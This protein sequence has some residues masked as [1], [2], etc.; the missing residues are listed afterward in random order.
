MTFDESAPRDAGG[1]LIWR[2]PAGAGV[3]PLDPNTA[4]LLSA[5]T[6]QPHALDD[7]RAG[8]PARLVDR[9]ESPGLRFPTLEAGFPFPPGHPRLLL[10]GCGPAQA[11]AAKGALGAEVDRVLYC[12]GLQ[13]ISSWR[14]PREGPGAD[15]LPG[16][17]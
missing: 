4:S 10:S 13:P 6:R 8:A 1:V 16:A 14:A 15:R 5:L 3:G 7:C 11:H 2:R 17:M 12:Y 9:N